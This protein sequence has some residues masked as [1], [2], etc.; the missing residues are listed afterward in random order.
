MKDAPSDP[1]TVAPFYFQ[2]PDDVLKDTAPNFLRR[3]L[4][5]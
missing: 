2:P 4:G 3:W 1:I 5:V